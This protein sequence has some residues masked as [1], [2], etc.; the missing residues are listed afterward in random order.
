MTNPSRSLRRLLATALVVAGLAP[1]ASAP[2]SAQTAP[3]TRTICF[4]VE[5]PSFVGSPPSSSPATTYWT[6]TFRS[7]SRPTHDGNDIMSVQALKMR[8]VLSPVAGTIVELY[9]AHPTLDYDPAGGGTV[10]NESGYSS[11]SNPGGP[12]NR[13]AVRDA[14]GWTYVFIHLNNDT[15]GVTPEDNLAA[16]QH[17][18]AAGLDVGSTVTSGQVLGFLGDSGNAENTGPH[19]HFEIRTPRPVGVHWSKEDPALGYDAVNPTLSLRDAMAH[20]ERCGG[21]SGGTATLVDDRWTPFVTAGELVER[22]YQDFYGRAPDAA[23]RTYWTDRLLGG[24][25]TAATFVG[26]LLAAPEFEAKVAPAARLYEAY[27]HRIPDTAGLLYWIDRLATGTPLA[28]VSQA[29]ADSSEFRTAY[30][31]L[32]NAE[33]VDLVYQ[34]V[35]G[36]AP[37]AAGRAYWTQQLDRGNATRGQVMIGFSE[38]SEN[39]RALREWVRVVLAYVAMLERSPDGPGLEHWSAQGAA[40]LVPGILTSPEYAQRV[41]RLRS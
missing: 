34:N 4:P 3:S 35:L 36:R 24:R 25:E 16:P 28:T 41:S 33:F 26:Q 23:G 21:S 11:N 22:Q 37:D 12:G 18:F 10:R 8:R 40:A 5:G 32:P 29:F 19:I 15:P 1:T 17:V 38:S 6:D 39:A 9:Y 7:A 2:A 20:P 30:G 27:F 14:A 31:A 13:I